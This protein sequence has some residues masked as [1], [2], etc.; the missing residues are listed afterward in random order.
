MIDHHYPGGASILLPDQHFAPVECL[1]PI[2]LRRGRAV[3]HPNR[4]VDH[5]NRRRRPRRRSRTERAGYGEG[6]KNEHSRT[7]GRRTLNL[8][9]C[10][11]PK[12]LG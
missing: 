1:I 7:S 12:R 9:L 6:C 10:F 8:C 11:A 4:C 2:A 3:E 5:D